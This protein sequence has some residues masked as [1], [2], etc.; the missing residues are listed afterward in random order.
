MIQNN[1]FRLAALAAS[2]FAT[3]VSTAQTVE[4]IKD[5]NPNGSSYP[6]NVHLVNDRLVFTADDGTNGRELW[7]SD[8]T[9]EGTVRVTDQPFNQGACNCR[10]F[11]EYNNEVY[12]TQW[13]PGDG[14]RMYKTDGTEAGTVPVL[15]VQVPTQGVLDDDT[16]RGVSNGILYFEN[17]DDDHGWELW[18]TD[19]TDAGTWLVKDVNPGTGDSELNNFTDV[20]GTLY[21]SANNDELWKSDGTEAGTELIT[22]LT[23]DFLSVKL[24]QFTNFNGTLIFGERY[25]L[26]KTDGTAAGTVLLKDFNPNH[27]TCVHAIHASTMIG[28]ELWFAGDNFADGSGYELWKTDG[29][30][31]GTVMVKNIVSVGGSHPNLFT[32]QNEQLFFRA[33]DNDGERK[34]WT[35]DGTEAGTVL[36]DVIPE[37]VG[38]APYDLMQADGV[39]YF[40]VQNGFGGPFSTG[41]TD[42]TAGGTHMF[43][44]GDWST[45]FFPAFQRVGGELWFVAG[46]STYG[47]EIIKISLPGHLTSVGT[48]ELAAAPKLWP[49][50]S[51]GTFTVQLPEAAPAQLILT[52]LSGREVLRNQLSSN[53]TS[54]VQ[55]NELPTGIYLARIEQESSVHTQRIVIQ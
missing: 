20:D 23:S 19:G 13:V 26:Y 3:V 11:I 4:L 40:N 17:Y 42:G 36:S 2:L 28:D 33:Y 51:N 49:N 29:T 25:K 38:L 37:D 43:D 47:T 22:T 8:G 52:D 7:V 44:L 14:N 32:W 54:L 31:A 46:N 18:R 5:I 15:D 45:G 41:Y 53:S 50:P 48:T 12:F 27:V 24:I 9:E 6:E 39:M 1:H 35:T 34:W 16:P 10:D 55:A 21:F 30:E